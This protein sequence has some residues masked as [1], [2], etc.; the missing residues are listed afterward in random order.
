MATR[1]PA[2]IQLSDPR[3]A[4]QL[5]HT[6]NNYNNTVLHTP[7]YMICTLS[8]EPRLAL[9]ITIAEEMKCFPQSYFSAK[10]VFRHL[11]DGS[12]LKTA[13]SVGNECICAISV[14]S[15]ILQ[16]TLSIAN[17]RVVR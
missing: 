15:C 8:F 3:V 6:Y 13:F 1:V 7:L 5:V 12:I 16:T 10:G 9:Q 17:T 2:L 11:R 14:L 4:A